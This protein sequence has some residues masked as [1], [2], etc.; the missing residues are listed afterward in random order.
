MA[1]SRFLAIAVLAALA[2][3]RNGVGAQ[4]GAQV[5]NATAASGA[6]LS[7]RV[8]DLEITSR[9]RAMPPASSNTAST[10]TSSSR[11]T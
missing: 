4:V 3:S 9:R 8:T 1:I 10:C 11:W 2:A 5:G 6:R 7:S